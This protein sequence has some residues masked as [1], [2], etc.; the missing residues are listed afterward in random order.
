[1]VLGTLVVKAVFHFV[2]APKYLVI[3]FDITY[4]ESAIVERSLALAE[5]RPLYD[6]PYH[7]P[8]NASIYG[9]MMYYC[10]VL[11]V[12]V[13]GL[14]EERA[15]RVQQ[16]YL[17]GRT[18]SF[19]AGLLI[20]LWIWHTA[21]AFGLKP[22]YRF[23]A[24][25]LF[26]SSTGLMLFW[27]A[28]RADYPM[29][30]MILWGWTLVVGAKSLRRVFVGAFLFV[31]AFSFKQSTLVFA[32]SLFVWLIMDRKRLHALC[33][34]VFFGLATL[35]FCL[36]MNACTDGL[37]FASSFKALASPMNLTSLYTLLIRLSIMEIFPLA[38]GLAACLGL[39]DEYPR[40]RYARWA[41]ALTF[42]ATEALM[43]RVGSDI[44]YYL[45]PY[46]W[47]CLL[48]AACLSEA[49]KSFP[50]LDKGARW[51]RDTVWIL[52]FCALFIPYGNAALTFAGRFPRQ[53]RPL[54][55]WD[56]A[57][58]E[59]VKRLQKVRGQ[60]LL[61]E[62]RMYWMT[63]SPATLM[64]LLIFS[65]RVEAGDVSPNE[66]LDRIQR[67]EFELI[68]LTWQ[69]NQPGPSWQGF[70]CVLPA[71]TEAIS[72]NYILNAQLGEYYLYVPRVSSR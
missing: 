62:S 69:L 19:V 40:M 17:A 53:F 14:A 27:Y 70:P 28:F 7:W 64:D 11:A 6:D 49:A 63:K 44:N 1:V 50:I 45:I 65:Q 56:T 58:T 3:D 39:L 43:G 47:G 61:Y 52:F 72:N 25:V 35:L 4:G 18:I 26:F 41:F 55:R 9:A 5:G 24:M 8:F 16:L 51:T 67:G 12:R 48:T 42:L 46:C 59:L 30:A 60:A 15:A 68:V 54:A 71:A 21:G 38:G 13:F 10:P 66:L 29:T 2:A 36:A 33:F 23:V 37:W 31:L 32:M 20:L 34:M 22:L 57:N